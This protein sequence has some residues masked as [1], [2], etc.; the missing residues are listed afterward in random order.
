M[1]RC[2]LV[3]AHIPSVEAR[4]VLIYISRFISVTISKK[5]PLLA[6]F[7]RILTQPSMP[8]AGSSS[9]RHYVKLMD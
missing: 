8:D 7:I 9:L 2:K 6:L 4:L 3:P 5:L 1:L